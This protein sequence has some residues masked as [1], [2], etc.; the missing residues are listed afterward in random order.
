MHFSNSRA[1]TPRCTRS[2]TAESKIF[3][4]RPITQSSKLAGVR[5][6]VRG[7]ILQAAERLEREGHEI[8]RLNDPGA[9]R[10]HVGDVSMALRVAGTGRKNAPDLYAVM[11]ILGRKTVFAR[12]G[13]Q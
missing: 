2:S 13:V 1:P 12:L 4:V 7:P 3:R 9:D 5:Y 6:D 8:L 11:K 10:G